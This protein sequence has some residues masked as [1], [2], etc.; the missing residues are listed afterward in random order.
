MNSH[1][2][3]SCYSD[4]DGQ[5]EVVGLGGVFPY[6]YI[7]NQ[8][9]LMAG[10]IDSLSEGGYLISVLDANNCVYD[11]VIQ[12]TEPSEINASYSY[13]EPSCFGYSDGVL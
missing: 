12:I 6:Q 9:T 11:T 7:F 2:N 3:T 8:D 4:N 13:S 10:L 5:F 1:Q